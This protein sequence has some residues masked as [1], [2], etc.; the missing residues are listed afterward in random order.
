M[1][2][3]LWWIVYYWLLYLL[4]LT[5]LAARYVPY[6][7]EF[8][9]SET[10]LQWLHAV[11]S[12]SINVRPY[13][14]FAKL[15]NFDQNGKNGLRMGL[16]WALPCQSKTSQMNYTFA[17]PTNPAK[18]SSQAGRRMADIQLLS[19]LHII[20]AWMGALTTRTST[21]NRGVAEGGGVPGRVGGV[22]MC[23][24][25]SGSNLHWIGANLRVSLVLKQ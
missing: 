18:W 20:S 12:I 24:C 22:S 15:V 14:E 5:N 4:Y 9:N 13:F 1:I 7:A 16:H 25:L 2:Y 21:A 17:G 3:T 11:A 8:R 10:H 19:W 6:L 23:G